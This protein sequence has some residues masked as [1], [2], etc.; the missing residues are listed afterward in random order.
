MSSLTRNLRGKAYWRSLDELADTPE[1]KE[2]L[3]REF[4]AGA[5]E[6]VNST[7]RRQF[8][9]IMGASLAL[10]GLEMGGCRRW[11]KEQIAPFAHRPQGRVPGMPTSYATAME[12]AGW[13]AGCS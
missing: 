11:P 9:R 10:A 5:T 1:F 7:E 3:F 6:M 12:Q 2:F 13:P 4:P 8:L